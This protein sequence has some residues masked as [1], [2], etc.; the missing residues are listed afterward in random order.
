MASLEIAYYT[1]DQNLNIPGVEISA[2][3]IST[4]SGSNQRSAVTP[5]NAAYVTV[6]A[7]G[8]AARYSYT[9]AT[10]TAAA[11]TP[12]LA[13]GEVRWLRAH[14]GFKVGAITG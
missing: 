4:L 7:N 1:R 14:S 13:S 9:S 6:S 12:W 8:G 2:E 5:S 10:S 11:T 3:T